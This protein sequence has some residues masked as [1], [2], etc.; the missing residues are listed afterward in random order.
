M[1]VYVGMDVHCKR[2]QMAL[3]DEHGGQLLNRNLANNSAE[4]P[5]S[6]VVWSRARRSRSRL[7][8]A[9]AG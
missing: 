5:R 3:L 8:M 2:S 4:L 7:P 9:G 1:R 6:W